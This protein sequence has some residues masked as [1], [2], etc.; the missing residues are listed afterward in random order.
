MSQI[1]SQEI[2]SLNH[3]FLVFFGLKLSDIPEN[4][5]R[6]DFIRSLLK[7]TS[8]QIKPVFSYV[9][10]DPIKDCEAWK[11]G[12]EKTFF[13]AGGRGKG[14]WQPITLKNPPKLF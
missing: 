12:K 13:I 10:I 5:E 9:S 11:T 6:D 7:I 3:I 14:G 2:T 4:A 1:I 8:V